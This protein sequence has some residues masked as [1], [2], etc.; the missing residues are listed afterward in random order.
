MAEIRTNMSKE[1]I[2]NN[3]LEIACYLAE[4][5]EGVNEVKIFKVAEIK[6]T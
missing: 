1:N 4:Q 6:E 2:V 3:M 5:D